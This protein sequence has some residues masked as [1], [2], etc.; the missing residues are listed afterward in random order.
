MQFE[1]GHLIGDPHLGKKF[2]IGVPAHRRGERERGQMEQ[3][4]RELDQ[5]GDMIVMV[6]DLFDTP[7]VSHTVVKQA[8]DAVLGAAMKRPFTEFVMMAGNHDMPRKVT[9]TAAFDV[10][11]RACA[12]R[13]DNLQVIT[14][15][16]ITHGVAL[17]PWQWDV[18]AAD[19]V[20]FLTHGEDCRDLEVV[21]AVGHWDLTSFGGEDL[22]LA[23]VADLR[24]A[25][26]DIPLYSGHYHVPG[27]YG[28]V[29]CTGSLQPYSHAEDPEGLIYVTMSLADVQAAD[30]AAL[31]YKC[32]RVILEPGE[33]KP[34]LD[35]LA[36][37]ALPAARRVVDDAQPVAP[38]KF[39]WPGIVRNALAPLSE[40]VRTFIQERLPSNET[41]PTEQ[42]RS[43]D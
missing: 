14:E 27:Q 8:I 22:H 5:E 26:G 17:F 38:D 12:G 40:E 33:E 41:T 1:R 34:V 3:F 7:Y 31:R 19:Q 16:T 42:R 29:S 35:A 25:F 10:F 28:E 2:D 37:T 4:I 43:S 20:R 23:P 18:S 9:A 15:P 24:H 11:K 39:D 36:V 13:L 32:V 6:G 30:P 21:A